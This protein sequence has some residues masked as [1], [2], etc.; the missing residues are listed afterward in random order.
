MQLIE[1]ISSRI[2]VIYNRG[3]HELNKEFNSVGLMFEEYFELYDLQ[4]F[5]ATGVTIGS[6]FLA[7]VDPINLLLPR[8]YNKFTEQALY[9]SI[10]SLKVILEK[11]RTEKKTI[12]GL[13]HYPLICGFPTPGHCIPD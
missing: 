6:V 10:S 8:K 12:I 11:A 5:N 2:P 3:N 9:S 4:I 13:S 1:K 7:I